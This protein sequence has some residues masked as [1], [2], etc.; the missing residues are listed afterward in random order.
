[1]N[2]GDGQHSQGYPELLQPSKRDTE[3]HTRWPL[4][5]QAKHLQSPL[6][7]LHWSISCHISAIIGATWLKAVAGSSTHVWDVRVALFPLL[8][9][10]RCRINWPNNHLCAKPRARTTSHTPA[11]LPGLPATP[12]P[13]VGH[14]RSQKLKPCGRRHGATG[15]KELG[16]DSEWSSSPRHKSRL[17]PWGRNPHWVQLI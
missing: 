2:E 4:I 16:E 8:I 10:V 17:G 5:H 6:A 11:P 12:C 14:P 3:E 9:A 1:M 13:A 15:N 7:C